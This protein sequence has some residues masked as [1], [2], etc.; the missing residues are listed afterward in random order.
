M[1]QSRSS[2][3]GALVG[4]KTSIISMIQARIQD[5]LMGGG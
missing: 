2:L 1:S 3:N 4:R 5:F